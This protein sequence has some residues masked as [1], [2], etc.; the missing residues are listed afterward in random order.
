MSTSWSLYCADCAVCCPDGDNHR[1]PENLAAIW[2]NR[3]AVIAVLGIEGV[4]VELRLDYG[5]YPSREWFVVHHDHDVRPRDEYGGFEDQCFYNVKCE[6]CGSHNRRCTL[7][8][9]HDG[10]H[11]GTKR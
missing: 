10:D 1:Y 3:D 8:H 2:K 11:D 6:T 7:K 5:M 9:N 4:D